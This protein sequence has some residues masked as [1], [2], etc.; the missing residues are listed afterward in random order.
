M[1]IVRTVIFNDMTIHP[2]RNLVEK[3]LR[4]FSHLTL[5]FILLR[6]FRINLYK[7]KSD[8]VKSR[9]CGGW[10]KISLPSY[11]NFYQDNK[12]TYYLDWWK[13]HYN[14]WPILDAY[15]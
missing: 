2:E 1:D 3:I 13:W 10:R 11:T 12:N 14:E 9:K 6:K 4:H 15:L 7:S 8:D 5:K